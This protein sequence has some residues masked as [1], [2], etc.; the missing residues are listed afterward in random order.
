MQASYS[1][2]GHLAPLHFHFTELNPGALECCA[3]EKATG[4][5]ATSG[6]GPRSARARV[7]VCL[8]PR[9]PGEAPGLISCHS[10][11]RTLAF[12]PQR[13]E[14]RAGAQ[15]GRTRKDK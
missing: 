13:L 1:T 12:R 5:A 4:H 6:L 7:R 15:L 10:S 14:P 9:P 11:L 2:L 3:Q 8:E